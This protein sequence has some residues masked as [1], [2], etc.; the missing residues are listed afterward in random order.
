MRHT[1]D[2]D[3]R[4]GGPA[5][6]TAR[7]AAHLTSEVGDVMMSEHGGRAWVLG[8]GQAATGTNT[9]STS[10]GQQRASQSSP[11][12]GRPQSHQ[13]FPGPAP[14]GTFWLPLPKQAGHFE[15]PEGEAPTRLSPVRAGPVR[16]PRSPGD[17]AAAPSVAGRS[18]PA[19]GVPP[20]APPGASV[21]RRRAESGWL[22]PGR[23]CTGQSPG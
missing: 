1:Q 3:T 7:G 23:V 5:S 22:D 8:Q 19:P 21:G 2:S 20:V 6:A 11:R 13:M 12:A 18:P 14:L 10:C 15:A 17:G 16:K 4:G 9:H